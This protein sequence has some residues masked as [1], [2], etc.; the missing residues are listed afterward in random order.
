MILDNTLTRILNTI[1]DE[2]KE[3]YKVDYS[4]EELN[5]IIDTQI[6]ATRD[7]INKGITV[8]WS[9][10]CK[11]VFTERANRKQRVSNIV[12][13]ARANNIDEEDIVKI[14]QNAIINEAIAKRKAIKKDSLKHNKGITGEDINNIKDEKGFGFPSFVNIT[15]KVPKR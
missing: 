3:K 8:H 9:R 2:V 5:D 4:I 10:F 7:G 14:K 12:D 11:F 13:E 15:R 6:K 1:K